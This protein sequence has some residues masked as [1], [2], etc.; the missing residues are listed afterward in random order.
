MRDQ[1]TPDAETKS[2][3]HDPVL[4]VS[5]VR[6]TTRSKSATNFFDYRL[7]G[8]GTGLVIKECASGALYLV[9][10]LLNVRDAKDA[11]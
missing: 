10:Q 11:I 7:T 9:T 4:S 8:A 6:R 1:T 3:R 5:S 2:Y